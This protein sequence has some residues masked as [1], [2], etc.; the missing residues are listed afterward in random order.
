MS[1]KTDKEENKG[2]IAMQ[3]ARLLILEN[4]IK[5]M[6]HALELVN[7]QVKLEHNL[8]KIVIDAINQKR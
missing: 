6:Q 8:R 3:R 2:V 1:N 7:S 4:I 5:N